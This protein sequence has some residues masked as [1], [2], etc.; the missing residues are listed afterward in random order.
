MKIAVFGSGG[1]GG[2]FGGR[3]A[4]AGNDVTFIARGKH[5]DAIQANGLQIN[6]I[7]GD[8]SVR[9]VKAT[10]RP[11]E[12]GTVDLVLCCVK[13]WQVP[14]AADGI[15]LVAG[16]ETVVITMQNGVEAHSILSRTLD[17]KHI[18]PG[19]CRIISMIEAPGRIRH[20]AVD[21]SLVFG[22]MDGKVTRRVK[23]LTQLFA[24][25][26]GVTVHA[27]QDIIQT[28]WKK[29]MLMAPWGGLG[30]LTRSP[31]GIIRNLPETRDMLLTSIREVYAVA[32]A[33]GVGVDEKAVEATVGFIDQLAPEATTSMQR[34][35]MKGRKSELNEQC[36]AVV[37]FGENYG[38]QTPLSRF[39]YH[40]L[41]PLE[42][43]ARGATAL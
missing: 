37:R 14:E 34:D 38:A 17:N 12:I 42:R 9:P 30:A 11:A 10:D 8:F 27:S 35:I 3:L 4:Q 29:L 15:R 13:S 41:L 1:V 19:V 24:N 32:L 33:T 25:S 16:P 6:S 39:I 31:I 40:S 7:K 23:D 36:G 28:L 18:L 22:E 5:L 43:K 20:T 26:Q 21:P 2:Y